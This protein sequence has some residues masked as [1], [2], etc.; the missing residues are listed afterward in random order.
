MMSKHHMIEFWCIQIRIEKAQMY[1]VKV[2]PEFKCAIKHLEI[3][4]MEVYD[5]GKGCS[6]K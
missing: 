2:V 1:I 6:S 3:D 4:L 5:V